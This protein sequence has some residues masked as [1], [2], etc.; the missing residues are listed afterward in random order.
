MKEKFILKELRES[1]GISQRVLAEKSGISR[2]RLRRLE[3]ELFQQATYEELR[4]IS[5]AL[6]VRLD[7]LLQGADLEEEGLRI[8]KSGQI[9]FQVNAP[10]AGYQI[11]SFFP[12]SPRLFTGKLF[13]GPRKRIS[14]KQSPRA[15]TLFLQM[16]LGSLRL[17]IRSRVCEIH[18]GDCILFQA[19]TPYTIENPHLRD[20]V[21]LILSVPSFRLG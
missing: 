17:S 20:A 19:E 14:E 21:A 18:E 6:G 10:G 1:R 11:T 12:A 13:V 2:G 9:A 16:L 7:E 15:E 4:R 3:G 5:N 8:A